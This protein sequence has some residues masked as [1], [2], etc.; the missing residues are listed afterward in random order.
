MTAS[1]SIRVTA[2]RPRKAERGLTE[3]SLYSWRKRLSTQE[4]VSF[5]P[6]TTGRS[7]PGPSAPPW[8]SN[9]MQA[10]VWVFPAEW[11]RRRRGLAPVIAAEESPVVASPRFRGAIFQPRCYRSPDRHVGPTPKFRW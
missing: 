8:N 4:A 6:L 10:A 3:Q 1:L 5:A 9:S 11:T 7:D 2:C